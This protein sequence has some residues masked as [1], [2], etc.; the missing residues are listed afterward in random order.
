MPTSKKLTM[1][2]RFARCN[3]KIVELEQYLL[4]SLNSGRDTDS[5]R[6]S[7][8]DLNKPLPSGDKMA[9]LIAINT[10]VGGCGHA[11]WF[12][13]TGNEPGDWSFFDPN[14]GD[15]LVGIFTNERITFRRP[16]GAG[17]GTIDADYI[18]HNPQHLE[19]CPIDSLNTGGDRDNPGFCGIFGVGLASYID[20]HRQILGDSFVWVSK[21][22]D[23]LT[24]LSRNSNNLHFAHY[25]FSQV[26]GSRGSFHGVICNIAHYIEHSVS[27]GS[28]PRQDF[29]TNC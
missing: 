28:L 8:G 23:F 18:K 11:V 2:Q 20:W 6:F 17:R 19:L 27:T 24:I 13:R 22:Q 5:I 10:Y 25:V 12:L 4:K 9:A 15:N 29:R 7:R 1:L 21:W 3:P 16:R 26:E 14:G